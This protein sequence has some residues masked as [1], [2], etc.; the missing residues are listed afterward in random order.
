MAGKNLTVRF[1]S[2]IS[3]AIRDIDRLE[4]RIDKLNSKAIKGTATTGDAKGGGF[5]RTIMGGGSG[6]GGLAQAVGMFGALTN[7][8]SLLVAGF[9]GLNPAVIAA[10]AA[11]YGFI[12]AMKKTFEFGNLIEG[13]KIQLTQFLG[14]EKAAIKDLVQARKFSLLTPFGPAEVLGATASARQ[15][16]IDPFGKNKY[17]LKGN[18]TAMDIIG[19]LA[20]FR[21]PMTGASIGMGRAAYAV[22]G[23]DTRLLRPFGSDVRAAYETAKKSGPLRSQAFTSKFIEELGKLPKVLNMAEAQS[24]SMLGM[25]STIAGFAEEFWMAL[26]GAAEETGVTTFWS[27]MKDIVKDIR[28]T[29]LEFMTYIMPYVTEYGAYLGSLFKFVWDMLKEV[30]HLLGPV[31]VPVFKI[32][33][34][35]GR[36]MMEILK[37]TYKI[38]VGIAKVL[39]E[40]IKLPFRLLEVL[41][42][43]ALKVKQIIDKMMEF[44]TGMQ[45][46]FQ[47]LGIFIDA[48]VEK[49]V[50]GIDRIIYKFTALYSKHGKLIRSL[51][52]LASGGAGVFAMAGEGGTSEVK[53]YKTKEEAK[54][55]Q[56][57][58]YKKRSEM[59]TFEKL[60]SGNLTPIFA[61]EEGMKE[62]QERNS[63]KWDKTRSNWDKVKEQWNKL[64]LNPFWSDEDEKKYQESKENDQ[65]NLNIERQINNIIYNYNLPF[66]P[67]INTANDSGRIG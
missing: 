40:I 9:G 24:D 3:K 46:T 8:T 14:S 63:K 62:I 16:G 42:G 43:G 31:L 27:Q 48:I 53:M 17:G 25:W 36:A 47:L 60:T 41:T 51:A 45:V 49:I 18:K 56:E 1:I 13:S 22:A 7:S 50:G 37:I 35:F 33:I 28:D 57:A 19:G 15:F 10:T 21:N 5:M 67:V 39:V 29:G 20:S 34:Q 12:H 26:S 30:W 4:R 64:D 58:Y 6:T 38:L 65:V 54:A 2:D 59:S 11:I 52:A 55:A 23:G 66:T 32:L 61:S 44:V